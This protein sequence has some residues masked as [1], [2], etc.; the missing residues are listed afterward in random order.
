MRKVLSVIF[1]GVLFVSSVAYA[2]DL[3]EVF[4]AF[5]SGNLDGTPVTGEI[6]SG[7]EL[8]MVNIWTTWCPPCIG[9]MPDLGNMARS[10]PEG[11]QLI[12][13]LL[14]AKGSSDV[15]TISQAKKILSNAKADFVQIVPSREMDPVLSWV[16]A[17]PTTIFVDSKGKIIGK[18]IV[19]ARSEEAYRAE[20][21]KLL[22]SIK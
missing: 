12:G 22:E 9:E 18:P 5:S 13:I 4:P 11:T 7:K 6:F 15:K 2:A 20:V 8:T 14:D 17:I 16:E 10:M 1:L 21:E 19:G 3:P